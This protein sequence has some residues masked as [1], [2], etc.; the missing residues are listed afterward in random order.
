MQRAALGDDLVFEVLLPPRRDLVGALRD[1]R[2]R[3]TTL[4]GLPRE[5]LPPAALRGALLD[6]ELGERVPAGLPLHGRVT[7]ENRSRTIWPGFDPDR[8][9]LV[10]IAYRWRQGDATL[11]GIVTTRLAHDLEPGEAIRVPFSVVAPDRPGTWELV[12]TL[13]QHG[14]P[15]FDDAAGLAVVRRV[16]VGGDDGA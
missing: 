7:V 16:V 1:A 3:P 8:R 2:P 13:R 15:W 11:P 6:V 12:L 14:G 10:G 4:R 9:G 5:P